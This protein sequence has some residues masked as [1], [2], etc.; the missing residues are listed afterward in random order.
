MRRDKV[1]ARSGSG[2]PQKPKEDREAELKQE[3][4]REEEDWHRSQLTD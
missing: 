4:R 1:D 3:T 2:A